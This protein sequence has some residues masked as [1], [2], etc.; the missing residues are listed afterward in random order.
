MLNTNSPDQPKN[1]GKGG[2]D[3]NG[4]RKPNCHDRTNGIKYEG[5][6]PELSA[7]TN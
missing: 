3:C 6:I 7:C 1:P 2:N 5:K 4:K